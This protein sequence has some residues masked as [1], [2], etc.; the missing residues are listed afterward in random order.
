M[1]WQT[2]SKQNL[3]LPSSWQ[4]IQ[5]GEQYCNAINQSFLPWSNKILGEQSVAISGLSAEL[6]PRLSLNH[7]FIITPKTSQNL[8]SL[9][10]QQQAYLLETELDILP[11]RSKSINLCIACHC[12]NFSDNPH[13]LIREIHRILSDDG[14]LLLSLFNP[15][16]PVILKQYIANSIKQESVFKLIAPYRIIDWL[17]LLNFEILEYKNIAGVFSPVSI[18][19]ARKLS[20]PVNLELNKNFIKPNP[21]FN[22]K[23]LEGAFK[24]IRKQHCATQ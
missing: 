9:A 19:V 7:H 18:I 17:K 2:K 15:F 3:E 16:S 8:T 23:S 4:Q 13:Q 10:K 14:Y 12:L 6:N 22:P 21:F 11:F 5:R 24:S 20:Y 1:N